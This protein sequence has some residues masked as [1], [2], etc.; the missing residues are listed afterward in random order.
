MLIVGYQE[1]MDRVA[2]DLQSENPVIECPICHDHFWPG[3]DECDFEGEFNAL[4]APERVIEG[5]LSKKTYQE[6][7]I[8]DLKTWCAYTR[9]DFLMVVGPFIQNS[10]GVRVK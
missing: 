4:D 5:L 10:R 9:Q 2:L 8:A 6:Q 7:V 3:C 1:W